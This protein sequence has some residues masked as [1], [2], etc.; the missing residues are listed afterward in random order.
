MRVGSSKILREPL[1]HFLLLG[2]A[3]FV[4]YG[5]VSEAPVSAAR[6]RITVT[7]GDVDQLRG[8]W[9]RQWQRPPT[10]EELR[11]LIEQHVHEEVLYREALAL[12]LDRDDDV[13]RRRLAQKFEFL[14]ED[15]AT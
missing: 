9:E 5:A 8:L 4:F 3:I 11:G 14:T 2:A 7:A 1:V 13:V 12:G 10:H 15:I 6:D